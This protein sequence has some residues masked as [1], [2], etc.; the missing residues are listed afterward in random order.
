[1]LGE[2]VSDSLGYR[3]SPLASSDPRASPVSF[4]LRT[5]SPHQA[6]RSD[7]FLPCMLLPCREHR[8]HPIPALCLANSYLLLRMQLGCHFGVRC[9][10][11]L[12]LFPSTSPSYVRCNTTV[13]CLLLPSSLLPHPTTNPKGWQLC[14]PSHR[15][16]SH[17]RNCLH[18]V[19]TQKALTE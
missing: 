8:F 17:A 2:C 7:L 12:R 6:A 14:L 10:T 15:G 4:S 19:G 5:L 1:M 11:S 13:T 3:F 9:L 18:M 16:V